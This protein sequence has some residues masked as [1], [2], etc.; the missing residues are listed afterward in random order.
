MRPARHDAV[1]RVDDGRLI[2][3]R[4]VAPLL[5]LVAACRI[6]GF[7][8]KLGQLWSLNFLESYFPKS[9]DRDRFFFL[10]HDYYLSKHFSLS[11]RIDCA[12]AHYGFEER[13]FK[14]GYRQAVYQSSQGL[15]LWHRVVEG[16]QYSIRLLVTDDNRYEGDLSVL[17]L[18]DD[19]RVCRVSFS[20]VNAAFFGL[21]AGPAIFVT[22]NR[23]TARS[24]CSAFAATSN[25]IHRLTSA[26]PR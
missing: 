4:T 26:S 17:C 1:N 21:P 22:R 7:P 24:N 16:T 12:I 25:R 20:Y 14:P 8:S 9:K 13:N 23:P 11:Q 6:L 3:A 19:S 2:I 10:T 15:T 5:R 18:V